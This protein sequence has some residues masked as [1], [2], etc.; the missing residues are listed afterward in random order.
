[1]EP[2]AQK[3]ESASDVDAGRQDRHQAGE[4]PPASRIY[5]RIDREHPIGGEMSDIL[6]GLFAHIRLHG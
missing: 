6:R 1:M 4:M 5:G 3:E 2:E